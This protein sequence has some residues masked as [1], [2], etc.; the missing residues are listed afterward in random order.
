ML[1]PRKEDFK[2]FAQGTGDKSMTGIIFPD[3]T[4]GLYS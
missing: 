2:T 3:G 4:M 1:K